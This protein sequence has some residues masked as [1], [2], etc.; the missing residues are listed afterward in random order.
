LIHWTLGWEFSPLSDEF[1]LKEDLD[2]PLSEKRKGSLI[3][4]YPVSVGVLHGIRAKVGVYT[5]MLHSEAVIDVSELE[6][7]LVSQGYS[8]LPQ[9]E[10]VAS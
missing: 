4:C 6:G 2:K 10:R 1:I 5:P 8:L 9:N 7:F 3:G